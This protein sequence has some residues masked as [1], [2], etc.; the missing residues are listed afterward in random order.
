L[1]FSLTIQTLI[2]ISTLL[3]LVSCAS[4]R[5]EVTTNSLGMTFVPVELAG[6]KIG[7]SIFETRVQDYAVFA[8]ET[9]HLWL[10]PDFEQGSR[11]PVVNISWYDAVA[12][13]EWLSR[14]EGRKCRLPTDAEW[15]Q[16]VGI[17]EKSGIAP[18]TQPQQ[19][20]VF[21]WGTGPIRKG[22]GNYC[23]ESFGRR[24]G[25]GYQ[26]AWLNGYNDGAPETQSVGR[27]KADKN[28]LFDLGGNVWEWCEDWYD[29][30]ERTQK[31][32]RGGSFRTGEQSRLLSSF[33]GPDPPGVRLDSIGFRVVME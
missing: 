24:H 32:V 22:A 12:F 13:C 25:D 7:V 27:Y 19:G 31:V 2:A 23:D 26:A 33:R 15:S 11:H 21:P 14:R 28:G 18:G 16:L 6:G 4:P 3:F 9:G 17:T 5:A 20:G 8:R 30:P 29:L 10:Q 1:K